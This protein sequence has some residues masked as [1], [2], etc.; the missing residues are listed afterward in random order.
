MPRRRNPDMP[1]ANPREPF[2]MNFQP[3]ALLGDRFWRIPTNSFRRD[4]ATTSGCQAQAAKPVRS[5]RGRAADRPQRLQERGLRVRRPIFGALDEV[6][7][8]TPPTS[9]QFLTVTEMV[10]GGAAPRSMVGAIFWPARIGWLIL[11]IVV[12]HELDAT[13]SMIGRMQLRCIAAVRCLPCREAV[14]STC[15]GVGAGVTVASDRVRPSPLCSPTTL[16]QLVGACPVLPGV[17]PAA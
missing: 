11:V 6:P 9:S 17:P 13:S 12:C 3:H 15:T 16:G 8:R 2:H 4:P 1:S 10:R 14:F 7:T 5:C